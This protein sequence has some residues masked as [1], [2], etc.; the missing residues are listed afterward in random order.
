M[1]P[2]LIA[3]AVV[4]LALVLPVPL[5]G[6]HIE[7]SRQRAGLRAVQARVL[8]RLSPTEISPVPASAQTVALPK[9]GYLNEAEKDAKE[10]LARRNRRTVRVL[11]RLEEGW[12]RELDQVLQAALDALKLDRADRAWALVHSGEQRILLPA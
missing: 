9:V 8:E 5:Y 3:A 10:D 12:K 1:L 11:D 2:F 6:R 4:F 7:R